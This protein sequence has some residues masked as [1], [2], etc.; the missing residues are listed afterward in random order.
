MGSGELTTTSRELTPRKGAKAQ[1]EAMKSMEKLLKSLDDKYGAILPS[2][3]GRDGML[4]LA[5]F[6]SHN[7]FSFSL[8]NIPSKIEANAVVN[9]IKAELGKLMLQYDPNSKG[10]EYFTESGNHTYN[11]KTRELNFSLVLKIDETAL[12][13]AWQNTRLAQK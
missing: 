3:S 6:K 2:G 7:P 9:E 13:Q 5:D 1:D 4:A 12:K 8:S 11:P 10:I